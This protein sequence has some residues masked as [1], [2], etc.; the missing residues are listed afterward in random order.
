MSSKNYEFFVCSLLTPCTCLCKFSI[1]LSVQNC[2]RYFV[3]L[4]RWYESINVKNKLQKIWILFWRVLTQWTW[5]CNVSAILYVFWYCLKKFMICTNGTVIRSSANNSERIKL[6]KI[7][8]S[9]YTVSG[10]YTQKIHNFLNSFA[11]F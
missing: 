10:G 4:L 9:K 5:L 7:Y 2:Y 11:I 3:W 1:I 6:Y 8:T